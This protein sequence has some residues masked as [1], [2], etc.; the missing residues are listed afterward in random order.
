MLH[1][2]IINSDAFLDEEKWQAQYG[3]VIQA[4]DEA[5]PQFPVIDLW[6]WEIVV[7]S[8]IKR[9]K[10]ARLCGR[11]VRRSSKLHPSVPSGG[12]LLKTASIRDVH[13]DL[14]RVASGMCLQLL[15]SIYF[16]VSFSY[17]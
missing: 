4:A 14:V 3:Q 13:L 9:D 16:I 17:H 1:G 2:G 10:V 6:D 7:G 15:S 11:L 5:A 12:G 8:G